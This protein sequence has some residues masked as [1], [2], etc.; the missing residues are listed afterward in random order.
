MKWMMLTGVILITTGCC[1]TQ[2]VEYRRV[3]VSQPCCTRAVPEV[4]R[5]ITPVVEPVVV[6]YVEPVDVTTTTI[7]FY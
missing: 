4:T 6:D 5:V 2:A 7:D 1:C 3:V